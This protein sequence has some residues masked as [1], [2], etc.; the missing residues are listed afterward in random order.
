MDSPPLKDAADRRER[1]GEALVLELRCAFCD[2]LIMIYE[3]VGRGPLFRLYLDRVLG[4]PSRLADA[5][6]FAAQSVEDLARL[7]CDSCHAVIGEPTRYREGRLAFR[8]R[9][10]TYFAASIGSAFEHTAVLGDISRRRGIADSALNTAVARARESLALTEESF[11][12]KEDNALRSLTVCRQG[13]GPVH[14]PY[15][16]FMLMAFTIDDVWRDYSVLAV[17]DIT[18][19]SSDPLLLRIDS[20][21]ETGQLFADLTCECWE[22]LLVALETIADRGEGII[23]AVS[24][25]EGRGLGLAFKLATLQLQESLGLDTVDAAHALLGP[26]EIDLRTYSGVAAILEAIGI[27]KERPL[28]LL[29]D[30]PRKKATLA[31]NGWTIGDLRPVTIPATRHTESNLRAKGQ[32]LGHINLLRER[33]AE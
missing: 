33:K 7:Q 15:G 4:P 30:N 24:A 17:G 6:Q 1:G 28:E 23:V 25:Q 29:S 3:K 8:L 12:V 2:A 11:E 18:R 31:E 19:R 13:Q 27:P 20:G 5:E 9:S 26:A 21:C 10:G 14:T 32:R 16:R 22:Q